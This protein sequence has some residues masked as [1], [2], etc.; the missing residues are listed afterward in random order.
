M[1]FNTPFP[2]VGDKLTLL[3]KILEMW[4]VGWDWSQRA[5]GMFRKDMAGSK[6]HPCG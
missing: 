2:I 3:T 1:L 4:P 5:T 6:E